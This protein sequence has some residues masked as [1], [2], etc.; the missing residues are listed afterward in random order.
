MLKV[1]GNENNKQ[2][3]KEK[4]VFEGVENF[5]LLFIVFYVIYSNNVS[6]SDFLY[7]RC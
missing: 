7:T 4:P 5:R 3:E 1:N 6:D 2:K